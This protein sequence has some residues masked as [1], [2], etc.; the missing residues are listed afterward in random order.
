ML[1]LYWLLCQLLVLILLCIQFIII[2]MDQ[3]SR[4]TTLWTIIICINNP[5]HTFGVS[6]TISSIY[7]SGLNGWYGWHDLGSFGS[8]TMSTRESNPVIPLSLELEWWRLNIELIPHWIESSDSNTTPGR[9]PKLGISSMLLPEWSTTDIYMFLFLLFQNIFDYI[10]MFQLL[11]A[12]WKKTC[13]A[14]EIAMPI[15]VQY[16]C[17]NIHGL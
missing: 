9:T 7:F 4:F 6:T 12:F 5:K 8:S 17:Q 11:Y 3:V 15:S 16:W 2:F 10:H 13:F 14:M 1:V